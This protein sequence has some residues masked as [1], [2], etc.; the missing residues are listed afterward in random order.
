MKSHRTF[1]VYSNIPLF[2]MIITGEKASSFVP[3]KL[4]YFDTTKTRVHSI[5]KL[6]FLPNTGSPDGSLT[7]IAVLGTLD[8]SCFASK[9]SETNT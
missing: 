9:K 6:A 1:S 7:L 2:F 5:Y 3:I 8:Q 4:K